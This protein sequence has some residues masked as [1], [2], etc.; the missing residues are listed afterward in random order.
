[1]GASL[2]VRGD[3]LPLKKAPW[4]IVGAKGLLSGEREREP[5]CSE[6]PFP[7]RNSKN[8]ALWPRNEG[9]ILT[10]AVIKLAGAWHT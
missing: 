8:P 9:F 3:I 10:A 2:P 1:M 7:S 6:S 5:S 4:S